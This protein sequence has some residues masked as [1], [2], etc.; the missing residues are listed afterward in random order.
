MRYR[1][2]LDL[3]LRASEG[4][5]SYRSF[6]SI[7]DAWKDFS[8][9]EFVEAMQHREKFVL[10]VGWRQQN[11]EQLGRDKLRQIRAIASMRAIFSR[12]IEVWQV[13]DKAI[14][15]EENGW[16]VDLGTFCSSDVSP[17]NI[18]IRAMIESP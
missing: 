4:R 13:L 12:A 10:P 6:P 18:L 11:W 5:T 16:K 17:R 2:A 1:I 8:F 3:M 7:P 15:L 9:T 14:L